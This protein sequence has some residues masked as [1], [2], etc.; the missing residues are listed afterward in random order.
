[1]VNRRSR[2]G[3]AQKYRRRSKVRLLLTEKEAAE[4]DRTVAESGALSR[5]LVIA[6]AIHTGLSN[7]DFTITQERRSR[8]VDVWVS[9]KLMTILRRAA[10]TQAVTQQR[11][12]RHFLFNYLADAPW[13]AE[14][15]ASA[16]NET[17]LEVAAL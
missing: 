14:A 12:L 8:R 11:L 15:A 3:R 16:E 4:L 1:M 17:E 7:A 13:N 6:G 5:S 9:R 10:I 2:A